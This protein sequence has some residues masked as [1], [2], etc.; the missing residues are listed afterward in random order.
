MHILVV[1]DESLAR[2]RLIRLLNDIDGCEVVGEA[3]SGDEAL[4]A[5]EMLDPD[6]VFLDVRMP[7]SDGM[8]CL[9]KLKAEMP[10]IPVVIFTA[11]DNPTYIARA[12]ALGAAGQAVEP[13]GA[14]HHEEQERQGPEP[15]ERLERRHRRRLPRWGWG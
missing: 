11:H 15:V 7:E 8:A 6:L 2:Q 9:S 10:D 5:I 13:R 4:S 3:E 14:A 1:D 12:V